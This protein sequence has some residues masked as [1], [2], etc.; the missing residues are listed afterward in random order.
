MIKLIKATSFLRSLLKIRII[1]L[2][3]NLGD[4]IYVHKYSQ[5]PSN[6]ESLVPDLL[7]VFVHEMNS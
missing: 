7:F 1:F 5:A 4:F 3:L 6:C 2:D